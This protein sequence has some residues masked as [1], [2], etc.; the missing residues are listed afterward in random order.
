VYKVHIL[1]V[2][3]LFTGCEKDPGTETP[4]NLEVGDNYGGGIVANIFQ[5]EGDGV[6]AAKI[7]YDLELGGYDDW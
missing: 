7:C 2:V 5:P 4:E 6:Y 3:L 1:S